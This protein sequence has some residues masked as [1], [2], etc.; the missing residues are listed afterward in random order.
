MVRRIRSARFHQPLC[1]S[2]HLRC[3]LRGVQEVAENDVLRRR[4]RRPI[5][6]STLSYYQVE[7][8]ETALAQDFISTLDS[9]AKAPYALRADTLQWLN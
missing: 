3:T 4:R 1:Q 6:R 2:T 7:R 9:D 8:R 5:N